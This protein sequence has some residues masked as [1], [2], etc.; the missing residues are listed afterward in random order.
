M[1]DYQSGEEEVLLD[2][3]KREKEEREKDCHQHC[4]PS[5][6]RRCYCNPLLSGKQSEICLQ[7]QP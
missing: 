4:Q 2:K 5:P 6:E 1:S 7:F 3:K